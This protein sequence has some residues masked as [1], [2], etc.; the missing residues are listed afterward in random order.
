MILRSPS[1]VADL[2]ESV[3]TELARPITVGISG[4]G[5]SGKS[6][7][8]RAL[9][10]SVPGAVRVRGDDFLEPG[11]SHVRS[12]DWDGVERARLAA[13]VLEPFRGARPS[14]FRRWDWEAG[15][16]ADPEAVPSGRVLVVDVIGLFHPAVLPALDLTIW[17]D[18]DLESATRRGKARDESRGND[19][20]QLWDD[21]W[22]PNEIA[23]E[24]RFAPREQA[25]VIY[26]PPC[27]CGSARAY[28]VCCEP[29]HLGA[30]A[31]TAEALMRSRFSA[32]AL[33]LTSYVAASWHPSTRP[34]ALDLD[35]A[36]TWRRLQIVDTVAGGTD[37]SEGI[38]EFR[39]SFRDADGAGLLHERSRFV[40][41]DGLWFY[42]DGEVLSE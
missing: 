41:D 1:E 26:V 14:T 36:T 20:D 28:A 4:F 13:E 23:F 6:T 29:L 38:V 9:A 17:V 7:L 3:A 35:D 22:M 18:V 33:G 39:A 31:A 16:L 12:T 30:P 25:D 15:A 24:Q 21:V 11:R 42:L 2:V 37:D 34:A 8:A 10:A 32:V 40:R 19:H 5:G 27:P